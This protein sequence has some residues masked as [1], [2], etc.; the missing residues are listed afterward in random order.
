MAT[1][2]DDLLSA[3]LQLP[4]AERAELAELLAEIQKNP[5]SRP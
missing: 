4:E 5:A 2:V 1:T 3:A